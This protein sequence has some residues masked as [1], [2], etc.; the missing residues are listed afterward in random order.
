MEIANL[1]FDKLVPNIHKVIAEKCR[2]VGV[3]NIFVSG[4]VYTTRVSLPILERVHIL[5][6]NYCLGNDYFYTG[7]CFETSKIC[8]MQTDSVRLIENW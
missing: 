4:L 8:R 5:I 2:R 7:H 1:I 3:R 6:S